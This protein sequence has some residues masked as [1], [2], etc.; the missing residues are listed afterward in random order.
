MAFGRST[1]AQQAEGANMSIAGTATQ[2][3]KTAQ[4]SGVGALSTGTQQVQSGANF[5]NTVAN[6][7]RENSTAMLAPDINRLRDSNTQALQAASTLMPR[8]GGRTASLFGR[9][10]A[11]NDAVNSLYTG[12]R[13]GAS[14]QLAQIG[15]GQQS[16]GAN[17]FGIAN[18]GLNTA[19]NINSSN[20]NYERQRQADI[21]NAAIG[22]AGAGTRALFG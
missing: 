2:N 5:F 18:S 20:L 19:G 22:Y 17:L 11:T 15:Q 16:L 10:L 8:G 12:V 14:S 9:P 6:G 7:N 3:S 13:S 21:N 1:Q 4:D